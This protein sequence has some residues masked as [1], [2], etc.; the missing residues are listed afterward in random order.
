VTT[1]SLRDRVANWF[2]RSTNRRIL[3]AAITVGGFSLVVKA[4]SMVKEVAVAYRFGTTDAVDAFWI[5]FLVPTLFVNTVAAS[6]TSAFT[7]VFVHTRETQGA[8]AAR[9]LYLGVTASSLVLVLGLTALLVLLVGALP[10][11]LGATFSIEKVA[12][13]KSIFFI[14]LPIVTLNVVITLWSAV[15]NAEDEFWSVALA[16]I[17]VPLLSLGAVLL[18]AKEWGVYALACGT[19][20][21]FAA[22]CMVLGLVVARRGLPLVPRW[23][24]ITPE[25]RRVATQYA[26]TVAGATLTSSSWA[27]GQAMAALLPTG[28]VAS[29]NY[30]SRVVNMMSEIGSLALATALLP[31][32]SVMVAQRDWAAIRHT[33]RVYMSGIGLLVIPATIALIAASPLIIRLLYQRGAFGSADTAAVARIQSL[34]LIQVPFVMVGMLFVRLASSLQRNK[35]VLMGAMITLPLNIVLNLVLMRFLGVGGIALA[36]SLVFVVS[37]LYLALAVRRGL[38][39]EEGKTALTTPF[40]AE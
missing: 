4:T 23:S 7:P 3:G 8:V 26:P 25:L 40:P 11:P 28:S 21:G 33:L 20:L 9:R 31:H 1:L 16:P 2:T 12:L 19:V 18:A 24:G 22:Q 15:L 14:L 30:G 36:T 38:S 39:L 27:I 34:L 13:T 32:F 37:C 35:I 17:C 6:L 5:A 10:L 29:L